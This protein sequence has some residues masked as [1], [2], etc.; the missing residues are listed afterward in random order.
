MNQNTSGYPTLDPIEYQAQQ[1]Y[2]NFYSNSNPNLQTQPTLQKQTTSNTN[3]I[4]SPIRPEQNFQTNYTNTQPQDT[5]PK[6]FQ[7]HSESSKQPE[8]LRSETILI[9]PNPKKPDDE[10]LI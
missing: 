4:S 7:T 10:D 6:Q 8:P 3:K 1:L 9:K 2:E 5:M